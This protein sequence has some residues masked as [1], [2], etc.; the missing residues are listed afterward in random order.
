MQGL[1]WRLKALDSEATES[2]KVITYFD[3]L[4]DSHAN[5]EA[6]LAGA[7]VLSGCIAGLTNSESS[8]RVDASGKK[9]SAG[10]SQ[11]WPSQPFGD[12]GRAWLERSGTELANDAMILERLALA[13]QISFDRRSPV[14]VT[15]R[16]IENIIDGAISP[17]RRGEAANQLH[18]DARSLYRVHAVPGSTALSG[19]NVLLHTRIGVVRVAIRPASSQSGEV[20]AGVGVACYP[21]SLSRSWAT[22]FLALRLTGAHK[23][24]QVADELGG[25]LVLAEEADR[26]AYES[27]DVS[28]IRDA[29]QGRAD[30]EAILDS[31][32][33]NSSLRA[34][35]HDLGLHHSTI[36]SRVRAL[37]DTFGYDIQSPYG[38]VRVF[39]ALMLYRLGTTTFGPSD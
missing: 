24:V 12:G 34:V 14:A 31:L 16:A 20:R 1:V 6:L 37:S 35:A 10:S 26:K 15:Q 18:L 30:N 21:G 39:V 28:A 5:A 33:T 19:P 29:V 13:L 11:G 4:V 8:M 9:I 36:Q 23:S 3:A 7:A 25:L 38:R 22:A 2:L 17:E 27:D 32:S